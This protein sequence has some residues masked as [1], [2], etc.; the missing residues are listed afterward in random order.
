[1]QGGAPRGG[2]QEVSGLFSLRERVDDGKYTVSQRD[3]ARPAALG[4]LLAD[5]LRGRST[6]DDAGRRDLHEV[7]HGQR[8]GLGPAQARPAEDQKDVGQTLVDLRPLFVRRLKLDLRER[9]HLD[10][11]S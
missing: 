4:A 5:A 8:P 7:S 6:N 2:Q 10:R 9:E 3:T 1:M 11:L